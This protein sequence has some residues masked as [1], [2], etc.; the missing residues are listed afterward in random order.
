MNIEW[1]SRKRTFDDE[2]TDM[3]ASEYSGENIGG[4]VV[5]KQKVVHEHNYNVYESDG[6]VHFCTNVTKLSIEM[7][8]QLMSEL[9]HKFYKNHSV[10]EEYVLNYIVDTPGGSVNSVLKFVDFVKMTKKKYPN[11]T[12]VSIITGLVAS[13]G[14]IMCVIADKRCMTKYAHAMI[15]ELSS[16]NAG[17]YTQLVSHNEFLKELH[18]C[19]SEIYMSS[20]ISISS[21]KLEELLKNDTWYNSKEYLDVGFIDEIIS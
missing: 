13:A 1:P 14:T 3:Y 16:G 19:L 4:Q 9:I 15:H 10:D 20:K 12:F 8:I 2:Y 5:K 21:K 18:Q 7:L 17:R 6:A 11:I